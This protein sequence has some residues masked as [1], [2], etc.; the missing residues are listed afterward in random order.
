MKRHFNRKLLLLPLV[1]IFL[2]AGYS[3]LVEHG[4]TAT[5]SKVGK[6]SENLTEILGVDG[7]VNLFVMSSSGQIYS[8][9]F[10]EYFNGHDS[11]FTD[12]FFKTAPAVFWKAEENL[13]FTPELL[14]QPTFDFIVWPTLF[15]QIQAYQ[16][17]KEGIESERLIKFALSGDGNI[18]IWSSGIGSLSGIMY[19][20]CSPI[21]FVLGI[22]LI[23]IVK[24]WNTFP[25][26]P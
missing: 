9:N 12:Q 3:F 13:P 1:G 14:R 4:L 21:G 25:G 8:F 15:K 26:K 23:F 7:Q 17:S 11:S 19:C 5:W 24:D 22:L 2:G 20:F 10:R 16:I 18:Y 6:P